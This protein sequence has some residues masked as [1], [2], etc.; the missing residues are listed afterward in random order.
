MGDLL[1]RIVGRAEGVERVPAGLSE[2]LV[3]LTKFGKPVVGVYGTGERAEWHASIKMHVAAK[4]ATFDIGSD[5]K[6]YTPEEAVD[7]LIERMLDALA[8]LNGGT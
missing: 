5:W 2:K 7:A 3:W 4:G 8:K 1:R 6:H